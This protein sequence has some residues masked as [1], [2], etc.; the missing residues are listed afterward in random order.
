MIWKPHPINHYYAKTHLLITSITSSSSLGRLK[1]RMIWVC[2]WLFFG[3]VWVSKLLLSCK[4]CKS[5]TSQLPLCNVKRDHEYLP[6]YLPTYLV[7]TI[8]Y[9][10]LPPN[11]RTEQ[12]STEQN[13]FESDRWMKSIHS[14]ACFILSSFPAAPITTLLL[15]LRFCVQF[16]CAVLVA[17]MQLRKLSGC[18]AFFPLRQHF[19]QVQSCRSSSSHQIHFHF[20]IFFFFKIPLAFP[21]KKEKTFSCCGFLHCF[22]C[23]FCSQICTPSS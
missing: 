7:R 15:S 16:L 5:M 11:E 21:F 1:T 3:M 4:W 18:G 13:W 12:S 19:T 17:V 9:C 20:V 14:F 10:D 23:P 8:T 22:L 6:T 2:R